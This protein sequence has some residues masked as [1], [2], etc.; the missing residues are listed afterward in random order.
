MKRVKKTPLTL[1]VSII[2]VIISSV[3]GFA[4]GRTTQRPIEVV[5]PTIEVQVP[6]PNI[7]IT[8]LLDPQIIVEMGN[9][10]VNILS[11]T[12][13]TATKS[14]LEN[15]YIFFIRENGGIELMTPQEAA[16]LSAQT[17]DLLRR[18]GLIQ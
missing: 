11:D 12:D 7:T 10:N 5:I 16:T 3:G 1:V 8:P 18:R 13:S 2:L 17:A 9:T 6:T 14:S 4:A 15:S